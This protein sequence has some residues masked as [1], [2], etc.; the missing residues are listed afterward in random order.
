MK[1][2]KDSDIINFNIDHIEI[3]WTLKDYQTIL[4]WIDNENS[5]FREY[6]W[7]TLEKT[8]KIRNFQYKVT[9]WK[10]NIPVFAWYLWDQLNEYIETRDYFV[11]YGSAFRLFSLAEIVDFIDENIKVDYRDTRNK[12]AYHTVKRIDVALD[13]TKDIS[14]ILSNFKELKQKWSKFFDEKGKVQT[15]YIWEKKNTLNKAL[16]IRVYDKI[17]DIYQKEK[18]K[19]YPSYLQEE[20]VTRIELEFRSDLLKEV[21]L[22]QFLDKSFS[23]WLFCLYIS[24]HTSLFK[25]FENKDITKLSRSDKKVNIKDL[26]HRQVTRRRY[27][28]TFLWYAKKFLTLSACPV[29]TLIRQWVYQEDTMK[30]ILIASTDGTFDIEIY[31]H[32]ITVRNAKY[33]FADNHP[34]DEFWWN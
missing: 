28:N 32:W 19:Y 30:D 23:F 27:L 8:E 29:D 18:Q 10:D 21:K 16:L 2:I 1:Q 24:K 15:Y 4:L 6:K 11:V 5:H 7:F 12:K 34:E 22:S 25:K 3:F 31:K 20:H 33:I 17:A 13:V 14:D 26:H 9:F